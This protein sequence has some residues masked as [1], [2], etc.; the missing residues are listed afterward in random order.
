MRLRAIWVLTALWATSGRAQTPTGSPSPP[1]ATT[2][3]A[4]QTITVSGLKMQSQTIVTVQQTITA[5]PEAFIGFKLVQPTASVVD[6]GRREYVPLYCAWPATYTTFGVYAACCDGPCLV[7][8]ACTS[9]YHTDTPTDPPDPAR[10]T[11]TYTEFKQ[12]AGILDLCASTGIYKYP[13]SNRAGE[14]AFMHGCDMDA[15]SSTGLDGGIPFPRERLYRETEAPSA[16]KLSK[17]EVV[18]MAVVI[19]TTLITALVAAWYHYSLRARREAARRKTMLPAYNDCIREGRPPAYSPSPDSVRTDGEAGE[20]RR[21][22]SRSPPPDYAASTG[23]LPATRNQG[24]R[25]GTRNREETL[26]SGQ[27]SYVLQE[28]DRSAVDDLRRRENTESDRAR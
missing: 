18:A 9:I 27:E 17:S 21:S 23:D 19:P 4:I 2:E 11:C 28:L 20:S 16:N 10:I 22:R 8:T 6:A 7:P 15:A 3:T 26:E 24:P 13:E 1:S 5:V 25:E 12:A 14:T